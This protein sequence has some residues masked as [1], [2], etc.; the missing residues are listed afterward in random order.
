M[1]IITILLVQLGFSQKLDE[2]LPQTVI[3]KVKEQYRSKCTTDKID[4][5]LFNEVLAE[6]SVTSFK[7]MFPN[8]IKEDK[9]GNVDIS[10]I[11]ELSYANSFDVNDVI[12]KFRKLKIAEY[13]EPY[14]LPQLTY[15]PND[16]SLPNQYY[17]GLIQAENAWNITQGDTNVVIGIT[18]TGW[19][20]TH[21]DLLGN[22]KINYA[23]P[24]NGSDDDGDGYIDNYMGWDLG[25]DDNN[26]LWESTSH[27]VNVTGLADAVT[28]NTTG[29][30]SAGFN[31][32]FLPIK[33]LTV[34]DS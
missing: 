26:A 15:T 16:T 8:K 21:P 33:F 23:D 24:I 25:M 31:C 27:G 14:Y 29:I 1:L 32:K 5:P 11:Y 22:V 9:V 30:A 17:I 10:L 12:R 19:D 28:D 34:L 2:T 7:K 4:I 6:V 3:F 13:V 20:P 18:D